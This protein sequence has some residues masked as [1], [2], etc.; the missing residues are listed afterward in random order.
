MNEKGPKH[1]SLFDINIMNYDYE[2]YIDK[3]MKGV[4]DEILQVIGMK[5]E[6]IV[7]EKKQTNL[8]KFF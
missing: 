1:I 6:D 3:Q 2:H 4:S 5:F 8:S 7:Y